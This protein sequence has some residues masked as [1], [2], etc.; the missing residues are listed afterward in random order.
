MSNRNRNEPTNR[1]NNLGFRLALFFLCGMSEQ[2]QLRFPLQYSEKSKDWCQF[3]QLCV[4][5]IIQPK[6][7]FHLRRSL[8]FYFLSGDLLFNPI[9][10]VGI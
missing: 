1:N 5:N 2:W 7:P 10:L 6:S 3:T 4:S 9:K 8:G